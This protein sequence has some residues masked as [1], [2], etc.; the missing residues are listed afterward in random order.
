MALN[1]DLK[2]IEEHKLLDRGI[3]LPASKYAVAKEISKFRSEEVKNAEGQILSCKWD[4]KG[5][6]KYIQKLEE[7]KPIPENAADPEAIKGLKGLIENQN[8]LIT[9]LNQ[10]IAALETTKGKADNA[11]GNK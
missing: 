5:L 11:G 6:L 9:K 8:Q 3:I 7:S 10:R 2:V 1:I 4:E